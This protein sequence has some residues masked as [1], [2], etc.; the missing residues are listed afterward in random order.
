MKQQFGTRDARVWQDGLET[1]RRVSANYTVN[2]EDDYI[3]VDA[4]TPVTIFLPPATNGRK[5][6]ICRTSG[7]S[8]VT[9]SPIGSDTING[10]G[11]YSITTSYKPV[12]LKAVPG[13]E[14][15]VFYG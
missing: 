7:A 6:H 2:S 5:L 11:S 8:T 13:N 3:L 9:L 1:V 10:L 4:S 14:F 12:T 15:I